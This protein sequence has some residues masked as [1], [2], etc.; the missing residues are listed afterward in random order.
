MILVLLV[1]SVSVNFCEHLDHWDEA[2]CH[3][4]VAQKKKTWLDSPVYSHTW[5]SGWGAALGRHVRA[6]GGVMERPASVCCIKAKQFPCLVSWQLLLFPL[7]LGRRKGTFSPLVMCKREPCRELQWKWQ[8]RC[9]WEQPAVC[10][11][12]ASSR[13]CIA[14]HILCKT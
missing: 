11:T 7:T 9:C 5:W 14:K 6:T 1:S 10:Q 12:P 3:L 8:Q 2:V 13:G 4:M